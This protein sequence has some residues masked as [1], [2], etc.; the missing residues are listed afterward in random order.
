MI[1]LRQSLLMG[2]VSMLALAGAAKAQEGQ[3]ET[4]VSTG[5]LITS[6]GYTAPTPVTSVLT[7]DLLRS[8]PESIPAGL[9]QLPQFTMSAS[10]TNYGT[11]AGSPGAGNYLNLRGLG[12]IEGLT[13]M[14]GNRLPATSFNGTVDANIIP[15]A[16]I[17]RVDVVT[18]GAS[19]TYGS[20]AVSGVVNFIIDKH[21]NGLK[22]SIQGGVST[23]GDAAQL[24]LNIAAGTD[25][26][27]GRG[28]F[29]ASFDHFQQPGVPCI[30]KVAGDCDRP[31]AFGYGLVGNGTQSNPYVLGTNLTVNNSTYGTLITSAQNAGGKT[32]PFSFDNY[33]FGPGGVPEVFN[34][35]TKTGTATENSGGDGAVTFG[36]SLTASLVSDQGYSRFDYSLTDSIKAYASLAISQT[37]NSYVTVTDGSQVNAFHI[38]QDNAFLPTSVSQAMAAQGIAYFTGSRY[39]ADQTPKLASTVNTAWITQA[40]LNGVIGNWLW[41]A[42]LTY[43]F[44]QLSTAQAGNFQQ[45]RW[46]AALDAVRDPSSGAIVCRVT[47]TNPGLY[48]GC[49]PWDP[50]GDGSPSAASYAYIEGTERFRVDNEMTDITAR[51][52]GDLFDLWAGPVS[53]ASGVEYRYQLLNEIAAS[54]PSIPIDQ[55]GLC[56]AVNA[57]GAPT[58]VPVTSAQCTAVTLAPGIVSSTTIPGVLKFSTT[59]VGPSHG[60]ESIEEG[61]VEFA[62]PVVKDIQFI[63]D[64]DLNL[65]YRFAQYSIS[66]SA[67]TWKIG[68]NW[69]PLD[70]LRVRATVSRDFRAPN[71]YDLFAGA[72]AT[73]GNFNDAVHSGTQQYVN[74]YSLGN[75]NLKPEIGNTSTVG[76]IWSPA[77][78]QG[79]TA[80]LDYYTIRITDQITKLSST[81]EDQLCEASGGTDP[82]CQYIVRAT[83]FSDHSAASFPLK[84]YTVPFNQA[85]I[86]QAGFDLDMSYQMDLDTVFPDATSHMN[87]RFI[88]TYIPSILTYTGIGGRIIQ[89]A[90]AGSTPKVKFNLTANYVDGPMNIGARVRFIGEDRYTHDPTIYYSYNGGVESQPIAYLDLNASYDFNLSGISFTA[91]GSIE[92]LFNKFVFVPSS[93]GINEFYP[94][95]QA[96]YDVIGRYYTFG[97]K[98]RL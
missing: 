34:P 21:F 69:Q 36:T 88:G 85:S 55:T 44:S 96:L 97:V 72:S 91:Y 18:G 14:D 48:P 58:G 1:S 31:N 83:P 73:F 6:S 11:Q 50:F 42:N 5:T 12:A 68:A 46:Y 57:N 53:M 79:F 15:Q 74:T 82:L 24:K 17:S 86:S 63:E 80:S 49:Q 54:D 78:I 10:T 33:Q 62:I 38:F 27:G 67:E 47:L 87:F 7:T 90:G 16:F 61:F 37:K 8:S 70:E 25:L 94:S 35:G 66:G 19:A 30:R 98:F 59:N 32:V 77:Y 26:F 3:V 95:N 22:G 40:G 84:V 23:F 51:V 52:S 56:H 60:N 92:N 64:F 65:A 76:L 9:E 45:D 41:S 81:T 2:T 4:V 43:G 20:D 89:S 71:L 93:G 13:L 75:P 28:H 29:E 39:E